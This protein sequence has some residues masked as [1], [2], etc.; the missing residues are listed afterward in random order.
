[1][2]RPASV[3]DRGQVGTRRGSSPCST[4]G[5]GGAAS[6]RSAPASGARTLPPIPSQAPL[7]PWLCPHRGHEPQP[8][9]RHLPL[10]PRLCQGKPGAVS[11]QGSL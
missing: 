7:I 11:Q 1:M 2:G 10:T 6:L 4:T 8:G 3:G 9:A 5:K